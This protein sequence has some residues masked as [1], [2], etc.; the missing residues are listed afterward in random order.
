MFFVLLALAAAKPPPPP[1][2]P[3]PPPVVEPGGPASV[4]G[5]VPVTT[6]SGLVYYVLRAGAGPTPLPGQT[7]AVH[8]TGWL[9]T[10]LKFDSSVDR[11]VVFTFPVGANKVIKGWDEGVST[12][13][14]GELRQLRI[15][16][17]L[18]YGEKGAGGM[19][20]AGADLVFDVELIE[21]R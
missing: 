13:H 14:V 18:G 17:A 16:A 7:V 4:A 8:Y 19:I 20:P 1:P 11:G 12:M 5:M 3:E 2:L 21:L 9:A 15:P 10:G 6:P